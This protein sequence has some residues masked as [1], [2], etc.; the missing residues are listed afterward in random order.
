[1]IKKQGR[2]IM[3]WFRLVFLAGLVSLITFTTGCSSLAA[4]TPSF[5]EQVL[6]IIRN[7]PEVILESVQEYQQRQQAQQQQAQQDFLKQLR[8]NPAAVIG[9]SPVRGSAQRKI[10]LVEFSDFQCPFCGQAY[11]T[12][13]A[14]VNKHQD[15][16]TFVYKNFPLTRIHPQAQPAAQAA[17]AAEQ[18]GKYWEYYNALFQKQDQLGESLYTAIATD[19]GL[20]LELFNRDRISAEAAAAVNVDAELAQ[21][22]GIRG[23]PTLFL[24]GIPLDLPLTVEKMEQVLDQVRS[25]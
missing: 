17:W 12:V 14:F 24:N 7:H 1:L 8:T 6:D 2:F 9:E 20:D 19:L 18:Q 25:F 5:E 15:E 16:V 10:V 21:R 4:Q 3:Q 23:T 13:E 22:V 11:G